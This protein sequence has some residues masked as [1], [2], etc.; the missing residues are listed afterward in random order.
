MIASYEAREGVET[1]IGI[2]SA[3]PLSDEHRDQVVEDTLRGAP[4]A[5]RARAERGMAADISEQAS[6]IE[7]PVRVIVGAADNVESEDSLRAAFGNVLPKAE[8][9]VLPGVG[10]LAPLEATAEVV[11]AIRSVMAA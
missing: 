10:H 5:K 1:V 11:G 2:L 3:R 4:D 7:V 9:I 8:F 6:R